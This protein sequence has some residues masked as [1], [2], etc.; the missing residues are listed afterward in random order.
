MTEMHTKATTRQAQSVPA[1]TPD[2]HCTDN[3]VPRI[4]IKPDKNVR[5]IFVSQRI[6]FKLCLVMLFWSDIILWLTLWREE[7]V[8]VLM[9]KFVQ[10]DEVW[11]NDEE[12]Q[13]LHFAY[14]T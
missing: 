7:Q 5:R 8:I 9:Y 11:Y 14:D 2:R 4:N 6:C 1:A 10:D 3:G 13:S 12:C